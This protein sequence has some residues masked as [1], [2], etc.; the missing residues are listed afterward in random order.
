[1]NNLKALR[2]WLGFEQQ[3]DFAREL[4]LPAN[5]Y[6]NYENGVREPKAEFWLMLA[7]RYGVTVDYLIG[8]SDDP[9][10]AK[11]GGRS[12]LDEKYYRLDDTGRKL[13]DAVLAIEGERFAEKHHLVEVKK[14]TKLIPLFPAA[15]GPGEPVDGSAFDEYEVE[16][17][18]PA[19]FAV[20]ISGDSM[21]PELYDGQIVL[22]KRKKPEIGEIGVIMVNGFLL[23]KQYIEDSFGNMY[24]RSLNRARKD[25]DVDIWR[26]GNDTAVGYGT[27]IHRKIPLVK[28]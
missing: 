21:E 18:S 2:E 12:R 25:L 23:V 17:E 28:E 14:P 15:A 19:Q 20:K 3:K 9:H 13:V 7:D 11:H 10:T 1:M 27:V 8:L 22:C 5:T 4:G 24:L 16:A 26:S 6:G